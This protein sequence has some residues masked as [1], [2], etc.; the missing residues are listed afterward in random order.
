[1]L[2]YQSRDDNMPVT[3][4]PSASHSAVVPAKAGT[5]NHREWFGED[6]AFGISNIRNR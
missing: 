5:H 6:W 1:M 2:R 3:R 4:A